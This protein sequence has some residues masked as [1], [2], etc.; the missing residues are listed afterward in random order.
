V[1]NLGKA[2]QGRT[3]TERRASAET[4][5]LEPTKPPDRVREILESMDN[6]RGTIMS[7]LAFANEARWDKQNKQYVPGSK[8]S[9]GRT[10]DTSA[11]NRVS[12]ET[13][14]TPDLVVQRNK[15]Y[16]IVCEAKTAL[17]RF[18]DE[19]TVLSRYEGVPDQV[20]K[21]DDVLVGWFT[22][23]QRIRKHD[24][25]LLVDQ[26]RAVDMKEFLE[27]RSFMNQLVRNFA[28]VSTVRKT[29]LQESVMLRTEAGSLSNPELDQTLRRVCNVA[30][31]HL[32]GD[33]AKT[34]FCDARPP[35]PVYTVQIL[36]DYVFSSLADFSVIDVETKQCEIKV[37]LDE[38]TERLQG[39]FGIP[40][41]DARDRRIPDEDWVREALDF[42]VDIE[43]ARRTAPEEYVISYRLRK[44]GDSEE[45]FARKAADLERKKSK[46]GLLT[47][48]KQSSLFE[49]G[50]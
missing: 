30:I 38:I 1:K 23:D 32:L 17:P 36:W 3:R 18:S 25:V 43:E 16:G 33:M 31:K 2:R 7:L 29:E 48:V 15:D 42:L 37:A 41:P 14:V 40:D 39:M 26:M 21:Y 34:K 20:A 47:N 6:Y 46:Q 50:D 44:R 5:V 24:L 49:H 10:M 11:Q 35:S 45:H 28:L 9:L 19:K 13:K 4:V 12:P 8:F 27:S 22:S